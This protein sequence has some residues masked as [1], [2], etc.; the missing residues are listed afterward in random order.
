MKGVK[1]QP[2]LN[3]CKNSKLSWNLPFMSFS[4]G[5]ICKVLSMNVFWTLLYRNLINVH[6]LER[7]LENLEVLNELMLQICSKL[8]FLQ[9]NWAWNASNNSLMSSSSSSYPGR[10]CP[11]TGSTRPR[12]TSPLSW[13]SARPGSRWARPTSHAYKRKSLI[14]DKLSANI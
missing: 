11:W 14:I 2:T 10:A 8:D 3:H 6:L 13:P 9:A 1:F 12:S 5:T 7:I 4:T